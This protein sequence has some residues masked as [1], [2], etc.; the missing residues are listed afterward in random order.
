MSDNQP[1][2]EIYTLT[3]CP[4]CRKAKSFFRSK[5]LSY[6]EYLIDEEEGKKEEMAERSNGAKTVPQI[7]INGQNIGG[8][9][10]LIELETTGK[11][12]EMLGLKPADLDQIWDLVIVG[13][14]PA[15]LSAAVY[16]ARKGLE[17]L[18]L[19]LS[20]GGQVIETD[21]IDNWIGSPEITGGDLMESFWEHTQKYDVQAKLG[22]EVTNIRA[23]EKLKVVETTQQ[24]IETRSVIVAT[25]THNRSLG[26]PG[27]HELKGKGVHYCAICDGYLYAGDEVTV[28]GGGNSGLEAALDMAKLDSKVNLIE[29]GDQLAGDDVLQEKVRANDLIEIYTGY[30]VEEITGTEEVEEIVIRDTETGKYQTLS[31]KAVFVEIG[32]IPN[33]GFVDQLVN[34]NQRNEI[35]VDENNQTTVEGIWAAGDVTDI[36]DKQIIISAAEGAKAAL[37]VNEYLQLNSEK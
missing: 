3:W 7:F 26:V 20:L 32:L 14:G 8:Y 11:L 29:V 5:D 12:N 22:A 9:D 15:G 25:G 17:V 1:K 16:G 21:V 23:K 31:T 4:Y 19:S 18:V 37:R 6:T 10:D 36:K 35:I 13:A 2:I 28:V 24:E 33:S 34:T 30:G 27:E